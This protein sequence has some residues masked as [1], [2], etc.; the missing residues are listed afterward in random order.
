MKKSLCGVCLLAVAAAALAADP[1]NTA[2]DSTVAANKE[3]AAS[4]QRVDQLADQA[5]DYLQEYRQAAAQA[6]NLKGYNDQLERLMANQ[7]A[8]LESLV[9]QAA[10]AQEVRGRIVPLLQE[11]VRVLDEFVS[12]D[13]PFLAAERRTRIDGLKAMLDA[14]DVSLPEKYRRLIEAYQIEAE[15]GRTIETYSEP[16][17]MDGAQRTVDVLRVGRVALLY[18]TFDRRESGY[19]DRST[20]GWKKL[21]GEYNHGIARGLQIARKEAP[22][23]LVTLPIAAPEAM[24]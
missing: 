9:R 4:Q 10:S 19:W 7:T 13:M 8:E 17:E 20:R 22:P 12:L 16:M 14:P 1:L 18:I 11:M 5:Q 6:E 2:I 21:P 23:E 15:Y 24:P 3:A